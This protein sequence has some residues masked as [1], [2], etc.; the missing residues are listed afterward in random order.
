M[1]DLRELEHW[2]RTDS[3]VMAV[4]GHTGDSTC[5]LFEMRGPCGEVL[6]VIATVGEGWDHVSV[7]TERRC[8]TWT[9]MSW[10]HRQFFRT[11]EE[12]M[13]LH[14][15]EV[16]HVNLHA[17]C[18]HIWRPLSGAIARPPASLVDGA[19]MPFRRSA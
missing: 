8:P 2:R 16:D 6:R 4:F 7:S 3:Q 14:V 13:Q 18:L 12:A 5:G 11:D 9:E 17:F 10:V 15:P 1:R 19:A